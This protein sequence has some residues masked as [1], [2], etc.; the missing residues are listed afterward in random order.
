MKYAIMTMVMTVVAIGITPF[1]FQFTSWAA[2][3]LR[4]RQDALNEVNQE[5]PEDPAEAPE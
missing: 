4:A 5:I 3:A 1:I 2:M